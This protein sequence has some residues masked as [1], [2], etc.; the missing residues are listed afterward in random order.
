VIVGDVLHS[1]VARSNLWL[2]RTLGASV[3][4]AAPI[5]L[6]PA[7]LLADADVTAYSTLDDALDT[8]P[9]VVMCLRV[10]RERMSGGFFPTETEYAR[11][12]GMS[13]S[14]LERLSSD[15][16]VMHPGPMNRGVEIASS[17]ADSAQSVVTEQVTNGVAARMAVL[18]HL[19]GGGK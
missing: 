3:S 10:Q 7:A 11:F 9:N 12:W 15:A 8:G 13:E 5:T 14:R 4:V 2:L 6:Q 19:T 16:I 18:S 17:V 1:R